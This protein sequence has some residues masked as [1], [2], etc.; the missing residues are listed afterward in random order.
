VRDATNAG[1][2]EASGRG[3]SLASATPAPA[4]LGPPR[5]RCCSSQGPAAGVAV[6]SAPGPTRATVSANRLGWPD[7]SHAANPPPE[8]PEY[9]FWH[10]TGGA[11]ARRFS[12]FGVPVT[13]VRYGGTIHDFVLLNPITNTPALRAAI[14]QAANFLRE[15]LKTDSAPG[16]TNQGSPSSASVLSSPAGLRLRG[17]RPPWTSPPAGC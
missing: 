15:A 3:R 16:A 4:P 14:A 8:E 11:D 10:H 7:M 6:M 13:Q 2:E 9:V 1:Q 5:S 17:T 12:R